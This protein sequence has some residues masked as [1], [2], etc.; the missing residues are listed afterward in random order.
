MAPTESKLSLLR[1]CRTYCSYN[2]SDHVCREC[3]DHRCLHTNFG[4]NN[5]GLAGPVAGKFPGLPAGIS[6]VDSILLRRT[7]G[8]F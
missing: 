8:N 2:P 4:Q 5:L 3:D 7:N 6:H 1:D